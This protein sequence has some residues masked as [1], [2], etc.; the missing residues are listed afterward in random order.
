MACFALGAFLANKFPIDPDIARPF[1]SAFMRCSC[2]I[3]HVAHRKT[4]GP[5]Q[6]PPIYD[7]RAGTRWLSAASVATIGGVS[8]LV[9]DGLATQHCQP[10]LRCCC[11]GRVIISPRVRLLQL[12]KPR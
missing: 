1:S 12:Q 8:G 3:R 10:C 4:S 7:L 5:H 9:N 2:R 6:G 11:H